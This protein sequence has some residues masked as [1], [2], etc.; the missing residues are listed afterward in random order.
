MRKCLRTSEDEFK[1][2]GMAASRAAYNNCTKTCI[3]S[4]LRAS[5]DE[6][7]SAV[8]KEVNH[9]DA[10]EIPD[11]YMPSPPPALK[12]LPVTAS[13]KSA[14]PGKQIPEEQ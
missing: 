3:S 4:C 5:A 1:T 7:E 9:P 12:L 11:S 10:V 14:S 13:G 8:A 6:H 2:Q